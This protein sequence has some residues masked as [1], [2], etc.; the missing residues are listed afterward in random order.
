MPLLKRHAER[1]RPSP[2]PESHPNNQLRVVGAREKYA[3]FSVNLLLRHESGAAFALRKTNFP[4]HAMT[5]ALR[6]DDSNKML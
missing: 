1:E 6:S 4:K 5:L 3:T 2:I